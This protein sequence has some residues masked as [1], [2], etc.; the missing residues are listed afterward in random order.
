MTAQQSRMTQSLVAVIGI[1]ALLAI[2]LLAVLERNI[3]EVLPTIAVASLTGL[4]GLLVPT[5]Q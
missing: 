2:A 3:P 1:I 4:V 5:R